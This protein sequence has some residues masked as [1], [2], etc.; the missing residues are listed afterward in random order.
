M[1]KS[2]DQAAKPSFAGTGGAI[3]PSPLGAA[4]AAI[5]ID[6]YLDV[7]ELFAFVTCALFCNAAALP[8]T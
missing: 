3:V 6:H 1:V 7:M 8:I 2:P 5:D 4:R